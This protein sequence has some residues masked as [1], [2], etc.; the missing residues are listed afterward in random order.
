M[1]AEENTEDLEHGFIKARH[2][3]SFFFPNHQRRRSV[4]F[5]DDDGREKKAVTDEL[6]VEKFS[7]ENASNQEIMEKYAAPSSSRISG[8]PVQENWI[9]SLRRNRRRTAHVK[10]QRDGRNVE[11]FYGYEKGKYVIRTYV[12]GV[13]MS[14][15]ELISPEEVLAT[16]PEQERTDVVF[17]RALEE[18]EDLKK[19]V[20]QSEADYEEQCKQNQHCRD[21]ELEAHMYQNRLNV[22]SSVEST[23]LSS[24]N[25]SATGLSERGFAVAGPSQ[26]PLKK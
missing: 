22:L 11:Y 3:R 24:V 13:I 15:T 6:L 7:E 17:E 8:E 5:S 26:P 23:I 1:R 16:L 14:T 2:R 20:R 19:E 18:D 10:E 25:S 4:T 21:R 9:E 12:N